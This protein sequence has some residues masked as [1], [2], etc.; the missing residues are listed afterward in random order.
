MF[1]TAGT[2]VTDT[3][4]PTR[5]D[6]RTCVSESIPTTPASEA[7]TKPRASGWEMKAVSWRSLGT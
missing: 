3:S 4:T 7:T 1:A 2:V 5:A 6:E